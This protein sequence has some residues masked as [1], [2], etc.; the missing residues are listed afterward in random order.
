[1]AT[2]KTTTRSKS[3]DNKDFPLKKEIASLLLL[4]IGVFYYICI[5][6]YN[7]LDPSLFATA[8]HEAI[9]NLGGVLGAYLAGSFFFLIGGA[10]YF[11]GVYFLINALLV[12][13]ERRVSLKLLDFFV[14]L[15]CSTFIAIFLQ[16]QLS[17]ISFGAHLVNAGG[18][19]G[20]ILGELGEKYFGSWGIYL[21]VVF[22]SALTFI[23][24]TKLSVIDALNNS[25]Q[26][27]GKSMGSLGN[28]TMVY[29]ARFKKWYARKAEERAL[30]KEEAEEFE[31]DSLVVDPTIKVNLKR[32][33]N[34]EASS[35]SDPTPVPVV[36]RKL[37]DILKRDKGPKIVERKDQKE[38]KSK[39]SQM[40][41]QNISEGYQLPPLEF[42]D[43][44]EESREQV[45]EDSLKMSARILESKLKDF[46][47]EGRVAEIHPG[48]VITMYEFQPAPGV[49]L[50]KI[51]SLTDDLSLAMGGRPVRIVAPLPNKAAIGIEIPN[52][53]RETVWL[54]DIISHKA[55]QKTESKLVFAL[56]K[57]TE[58]VPYVSDLQK[59]PHL[60]VAGSTGSGKSVSVN[61]MITSVLYNARP[62][63]VRMIMI[64]PKMIELS[65]YQGIP[66]L[67]L[68]VVTDPGKANLSLKWAVREMERRYTLLADANVRN[69]AGY[70]KG[71]ETGQIKTKDQD[72]EADRDPI[73]HDGKL[74]LV[75]IVIDEF[76]DLMMVASKEVEESVCRL[77]Q[78]ARAAG[79]HVILATQRPSVD[80]ITGI[81]KA[82]FPARMSFRVT[83]KH[84]SRTILDHVGAEHLLGMGDMLFVPP[85]KSKMDRLHGAFVSEKEIMRIVEHVKAQ[86]QPAYNEEILKEP[87]P[88]A[89]AEGGPEEF[90]ELYDQAV[91][92]VCESNRV[93]IS[94]I[95]RQFRIGYNRA[96]RIVEQM[97][98]QGIVSSPNGQGARQVLVEAI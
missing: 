39:S 22:G 47:I 90:D 36:K 25:T 2:K 6:S 58:G 37:E 64:D 51:S 63:E 50:S 8:S 46:N 3:G 26:M 55:F 79:I 97:E 69:L 85:G 11:L 70:N 21:L 81:I 95:Q 84:D 15:I 96:A 49:K 16:L 68:P 60:L 75:M 66:H 33:A 76:A 83:S 61:T 88:V 86:A 24:A 98:S 10:S 57:D 82:N 93:S 59:M 18:S 13:T 41:L 65:I 34:D 87:E 44:E 56:G 74:P 14:F 92:I 31:E 72:I 45:D 89:G 32:N 52:H 1:M 4:A 20:K 71:I 54:K 43:Y 38:K 73:I 23:L 78:K 42:L 9:S 48:P 77:A 53:T 67:L 7:P 29:L 80:V 19:I 17:E 35:G 28:Q 12:F 27:L 62:D 30:S 91:R 5:L 40:E 94:G